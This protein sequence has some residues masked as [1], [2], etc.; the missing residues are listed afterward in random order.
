MNAAMAFIFAGLIILA[1]LA[2]GGPAR[3][4]VMKPIH[5]AKS[6]EVPSPRYYDE[7]LLNYRYTE[8]CA[9]V[10]K[11]PPVIAEALNQAIVIDPQKWLPAIQWWNKI[12]EKYAEAKCG[13][14]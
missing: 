9:T 8:F 5:L 2:F 7:Q 1:L 11:P 6:A 12:A 10:G 14:A 4:D 13:D 3:A